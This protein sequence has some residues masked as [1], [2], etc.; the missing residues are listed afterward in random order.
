MP[1]STDDILQSATFSFTGTSGSAT[2]PAGTQEGSPVIIAVGLGGDN[3]STYSMSPPA[4]FEE[5]NDPS[6]G[7]RYGYVY[8]FL[9]RAASA[10]ETSWTLTVTGG[11]QQVCGAVLE[12]PGL[13]TADGVYMMTMTNPFTPGTPVASLSTNPSATSGSYDAMGLAIYLA[14]NLGADIPVLSGHSANWQEIASASVTDGSTRSH[15][16]SLAARPSITLEVF[17]DTASVTPNS[18]IY[19]DLSVFTSVTARHAPRFEAVAGFEWGTATSM[20]NASIHSLGGPAPFDAVAGSPA[21][22]STNPRTGNWCLELSSVAAAEWV[23]WTGRTSPLLGNLG[24]TGF[25][26]YLWVEP[27]YFLFPGSLPAADVEIA[28]VEAGSL[29][30]GVTIWYRSATQKIGVKVGSGTEVASDA[31][32]AADTWIG[33]DYRY[34][35]QATTHVCDWQIDYNS[36]DDTAAA[37]E[38]TQATG[39]SMSAARV[40]TVRK[41]WTTPRTATIRYDD[42]AGSATR[43]AYPIGRINIHPLKVDPAGT[44]TVVGTAANFQTFTSNGG[45]MTAFDPAGVRNALDDLPPTIGA[46]ADGLAQITTAGTDYVDIPMQTYTAAPDHVLRAARWYL[47]LWAGSATAAMLGWNFCDSSGIV[48]GGGSADHGFDS[49]SLLWA[50]R[51]HQASSATFNL[52]TQAKV[53]SLSVRVG[54]SGDASPDVGIHCVLAELVTQPAQVFI[55]SESGQ[56]HTVYVRQD[57]MSGAIAS[58]TVVTPSDSGGTLYGTIG[59]TD[60]TP[61]YVPPAD[62]YVRT[63]GASDVG[64]VTSLGFSPDATA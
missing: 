4:G 33:I 54:Y 60:F 30:N 64:D 46:A 38:Q 28:S 39:A 1:L 26:P 45:T 3:T 25:G 52:L 41:G 56:G 49:T 48:A 44:P 6:V 8:L 34:D 20:T 35:P 51:M 63:I 17:Q 24:Y 40:S 10:G 13:D 7:L 43:K 27:F 22:V 12:W 55:A 32:V 31:V 11:S 21:V 36:L 16:M 15:A 57:P 50:T 29:T 2:L 18:Y 19:C 37:V 47:A 23:A 42:M 59:G 58:V 53:D 62:I 14:T 9:K 5:V 61:V